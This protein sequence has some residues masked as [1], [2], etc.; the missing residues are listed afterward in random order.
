MQLK[1]KLKIIFGIIAAL[2]LFFSGFAAH[3][4]LT[5]PEKYEVPEETVVEKT[6]FRTAFI[7]EVR[8]KQELITLE[9]DLSEEIVLDDSWTNWDIFK[10][11][12]QIEYKATGLF[13][14]DL[15]E[16]EDDSILIDDERKIVQVKL[17]AP[18][19]KSVQLDEDKTE[20]FAVENGLLRSTS[21]IKL[22]ASEQQKLMKQI[23]AVM[24]EEMNSLELTEQAKESA[25]ASVTHLYQSILQKVDAGDYTVEVIFDEKLDR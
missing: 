19:V 4:M 17:S 16:I 6:H 11:N 9:V 13:T 18:T 25:R 3:A 24:L 12:Q 22:T 2:V 10:K 23:K 21:E 14:V 5:K 15:G 8:T 7:E 20:Y 1:T